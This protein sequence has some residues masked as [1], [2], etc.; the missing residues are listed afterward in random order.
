MNPIAL[1]RRGHFP[2]ADSAKGKTMILT[3]MA[4]SPSERLYRSGIVKLKFRLGSAGGT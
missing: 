1:V 2:F 4:Q 3:L